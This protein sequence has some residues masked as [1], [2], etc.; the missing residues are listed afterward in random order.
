M[1][2]YIAPRDMASL[3]VATLDAPP[4]N[5]VFDLYSAAPVSKFEA[6]E[7]FSVRYGLK[8]DVLET[9][10][11]LTATGLKPNHYSTNRRAASVGYEPS[12]TSLETLTEEIDALLELH[13]GGRP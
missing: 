3:L 9:P 12:L 5:D 4:R 10:A 6:L 7:E 11:T 13:G 1:R 2:D 8:Y